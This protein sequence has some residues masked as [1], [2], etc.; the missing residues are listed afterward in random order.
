MAR[1]TDLRAC[2]YSAAAAADDVHNAA[3][4]AGAEL[5]STGGQREQG[6]VA[7]AAYAGARVEVGAALADDDLACGNYLAAE[8]LDAEVLCVRCTPDF[9]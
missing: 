5:D 3:T 4:T 6:V 2:C 8:A 9:C 7:A 1:P